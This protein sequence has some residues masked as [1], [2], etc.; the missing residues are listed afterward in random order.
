[1]S[2]ADPIEGFVYMEFFSMQQLMEK[3]NETLEGISNVLYGS[4][5]LTS[6]I[7]KDSATLLK[8]S[9]PVS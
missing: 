5:L 7:E 6:A 1:M 9:V 4:G 2:S 3:I 8:S